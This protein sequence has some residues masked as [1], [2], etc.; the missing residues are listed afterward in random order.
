MLLHKNYIYPITAC[1][2]SVNNHIP[3]GIKLTGYNP[4]L[5]YEVGFFFHIDHEVWRWPEQEKEQPPDYLNYVVEQYGYKKDYFLVEWLERIG[6][7]K[8][9]SLLKIDEK[10]CFYINGLN[11][12][13]LRMANALDIII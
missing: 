10:D 8:I 5:C 1:I 13:F 9:I 7:R 4:I 12:N 6:F 2:I 3:V 11:G